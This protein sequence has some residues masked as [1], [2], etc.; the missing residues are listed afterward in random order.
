MNA[1]YFPKA[2]AVDPA[3]LAEEQA[4]IQREGWNH[5]QGRYYA[6]EADS[7]FWR[8]TYAESIVAERNRNLERIA[9][10]R[11]RDTMT[12]LGRQMDEDLE[13]WENAMKE[14]TRRTA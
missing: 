3:V 7:A 8:R 4:I 14:P 11:G 9:T 12:P 5:V 10:L 2:P 13:R 6:R 1:I